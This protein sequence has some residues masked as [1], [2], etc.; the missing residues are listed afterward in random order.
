MLTKLFLEPH[1]LNRRTD[2]SPISPL[3]LKR[4]GYAGRK[5]RAWGEDEH[6]H[7]LWGGWQAEAG[8]SCSS[9][10]WKPSQCLWAAQFLPPAKFANC[11]IIPKGPNLWPIHIGYRFW[12]ALLPT[13]FL[14]IQV[15]VLLPRD[16]LCCSVGPCLPPRP[17][18]QGQLHLP[19]SSAQ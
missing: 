8:S 3:H 18:G 14:F 5:A 19:S 11:P 9:P 4:S 13:L 7:P 12:G 16:S 6:S 1:P 10:A 17:G 15:S 2:I